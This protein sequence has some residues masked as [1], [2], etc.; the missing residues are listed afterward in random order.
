MLLKSLAEI[1]FDDVDTTGLTEAQKTALITAWSI[2]KSNFIE[3]AR[4]IFAEFYEQH[5][6]YLQL[7]DGLENA[8]MHRHT[9]EVLKLYTTLID[10]GLRNPD[11]FNSQLFRIS[12]LHRDVTG[13]DSA[14]LNRIIKDFVLDQVSRHKT[15]TLEDAFDAFFLQ[16]ESKFEDSFDWNGQEV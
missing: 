4:N 14:K 3:N 12:R 8:A 13:K 16:I 5:P 6:G 11:E 15:K 10:H 2:F 7:F 1:P 9:E